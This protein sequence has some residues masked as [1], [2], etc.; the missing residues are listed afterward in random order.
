MIRNTLRS[1]ILA[2][3]AGVCVLATQNANAHSY[4]TPNF[5]SATA[6]TVC[7]HL[8]SETVPNSTDESILM[9]HFMPKAGVNVKEITNVAVKL[10]MDDMGHGSSPVT[11]VQL[12]DVHFEVSKAFF[13]MPGA[14]QVKVAFDYQGAKH[15]IVIPV[16]V[17]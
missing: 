10:W 14:W 4:H 6:N 13:I 3:A 7:A 8:G 12:D 2:T 9:L 16:D 15:E 17:K 11:V 5:C 1:F